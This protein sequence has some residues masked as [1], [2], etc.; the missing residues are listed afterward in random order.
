MLCNMAI[1]LLLFAVTADILPSSPHGEDYPEVHWH[2]QQVGSWSLPDPRGEA[3]LH[4]SSQEGDPEPR[5]Y[6]LNAKAFTV[7]MHYLCVAVW[8]LNNKKNSMEI[9]CVCTCLCFFLFCTCVSVPT[10]LWIWSFK[11]YGQVQGPLYMYVK[12]F[13]S[14]NGKK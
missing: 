3:Q 7:V 2:R 10:D 1:I 11:L 13:K 9:F 5:G 6:L 12:Y 4:G 8:N 14:Q